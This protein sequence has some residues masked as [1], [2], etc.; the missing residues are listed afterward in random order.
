MNTSDTVESPIINGPIVNSPILTAVE[1]EVPDDFN[2]CC[3]AGMPAGNRMF[4][5][6]FVF[7]MFVILGGGLYGLYKFGASMGWFG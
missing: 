6:K 5:F 3:A 2:P 4:Y 7:I 1:S